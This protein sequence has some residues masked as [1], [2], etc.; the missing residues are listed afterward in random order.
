[1]RR[2]GAS[3]KSQ[4]GTRNTAPTDARSAFGPVGSAQPGESATNAPKASAARSTVL[5]EDGDHPWRMAERRELGEQRRLDELGAGHVQ[6]AL[7]VDERRFRP[8]PR[9]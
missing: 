9:R 3:S 8:E 1:M 6:R 4:V 7:G 5:P 2:P